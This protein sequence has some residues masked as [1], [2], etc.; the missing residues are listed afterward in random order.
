MDMEQ[1]RSTAYHEAG[2]A[3][4]GWALKLQIHRLRI[5]IQGDAGKGA[6]DMERNEA[7]SLVDRI[8]ICY[9]GIAAQDMLQ[10]ETH[11]L[12]GMMDENCVRELL[13]DEHEDSDEGFRLRDAGYD[14]ARS[15]LELHRQPLDRIAAAL[16][17][18][19][20]LAQPDVDRL[21]VP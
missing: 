10:L 12:A 17:S 14:R 5:G 11:E 9:G 4:V 3:I 6:A 21:L 8:A 2:H 15:L 16:S 20:T 18:A 7:L 13:G 19:L 1:L